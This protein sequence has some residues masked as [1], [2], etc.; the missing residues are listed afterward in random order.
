MTQTVQAVDR[1][2]RLL[3]EVHARPEASLTEL[4][5]TV[6]LLP[7]TALRLLS[8]L[9]RHG[10]VERDTMT[11]GFRMGPSAL[12]L[13]G[14][15]SNRNALTSARLEPVVQRLSHTVLEQVSLAVLAGRLVERVLT[16]DGAREGGH[17]VI[18]RPNRG[19]L[20]GNLNATALGKVFLAFAADPVA[21]DI[22][23]SLSFVATASR[24]ITD[25]ETLRKHLRRV[26]QQQIAYSIAEN[27]QHVAG[28]AAP[29]L[30]SD[31]KRCLAAIAVHGPSSRL[32]AKHL[33]DIAPIL[34]AA[35]VECTLI[36]DPHN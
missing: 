34:R 3:W 21:D 24:T 7:S 17:E 31:R 19:R 25:P 32:N 30:S 36:L 33:R 22:I 28:V 14:G 6:G 13:G 20:D 29:I 27:T 2:L 35:A 1:A 12:A 16:V 4:S 10:V 9:E 8:T 5:S 15:T 26:R 18:L 23:S 11:R